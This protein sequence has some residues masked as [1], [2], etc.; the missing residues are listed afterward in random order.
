MKREDV[1]TVVRAAYGTIAK[2]ARSGCGPVTSC[3]GPADA[4]R[5]SSKTIDYSEAE[6]RGVPE[7]ADL[8]LGCGNPVA[9]ASLREGETVLDLGSGAG[10]DAFLA[11]RRVGKSGRVIGVD[12][13]PAMIVRA[14]ENAKHGDYENVEFRLGE[15]EDLPVADNAVDVVLS[16]CVI[17]LSPDKPQ[18]F[19]EAYRVLKPGGRLMIADI[20]LL[21][22]LPEPVKHSVEAYTG[23]VAGAM[24]K[25]E[26]V[27]AIR[28]AGFEDVRIVQRRSFPGEDLENGPSVA[29]SIE[30]SGLMTEENAK[31]SSS[32]QSVSI[33]GVKPRA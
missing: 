5:E 22:E 24:L 4:G 28:A 17:N 12:M 29:T 14:E 7:G 32:V 15:I 8:G 6:L 3:C 30:E 1:K 19:R 2:Q 33:S 10:L 27:A 21:E 20:V 31:L 25:D 9:I 11:A 26:Y 23:C 13:T 16:N 18:V